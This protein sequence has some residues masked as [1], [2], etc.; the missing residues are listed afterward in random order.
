MNIVSLLILK[1]ADS[2]QNNWKPLGL[3]QHPSF[4]NQQ[5]SS[6]QYLGESETEVDDCSQV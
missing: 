1:S 6:A 3:T 4:H 5:L 2:T